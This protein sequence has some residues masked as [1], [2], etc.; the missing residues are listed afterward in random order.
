[1][2]AQRVG[3]AA[4]RRAVLRPDAAQGGSD[5]GHLHDSV[6]V[7]FPQLRSC[8]DAATFSS[9]ADPPSLV[10]RPIAS[11]SLT[12]AEGQKILVNQRLNR[13]ISPHLGIY[14][15]EQTWF[16]S[17][18]WTRITGCTLSGAMYVYMASYL[19]APLAGLHLESASFAAAFG[20]LPFIVKGGIKFGLGFPFAYHFL[21][22]LKHLTYDL[23]KGFAKPT[24]IKAD[25]VL[26]ASSLI[27]GL[28]LAFLV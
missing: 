2:I 4:L 25:R 10:P 11:T 18:A 15:M 22:G 16:G 9:H 28:V 17:S 14:K 24:I 20:S 26:W 3:V 23:G 13:P 7:G 19:V 12:P 5:G 1:M 8:N 27:G 21:S 6:P